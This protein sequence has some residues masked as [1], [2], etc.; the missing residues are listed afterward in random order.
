MVVLVFGRGTAYSDDDAH[1]LRELCAGFVLTLAVSPFTAPF[2]TCAT[3]AGNQSQA[4]AVEA[5]YPADD[6]GSL[7]G[8]V[9]TR[10]LQLRLT[11]LAALT[12]LTATISVHEVVSLA[13]G[14][15]NSVRQLVPH[16]IFA[17]VLRV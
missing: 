13:S 8:P 7:I 12:G 16:L 4:P 15:G 10:Q 3:D 11:P 2:Q 14:F 1:M 5:T 6:V 17:V 9:Q